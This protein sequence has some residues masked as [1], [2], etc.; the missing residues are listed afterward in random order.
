MQTVLTDSLEKVLGETVPRP[1]ERHDGVQ[2][3]GFL[4]EVLSVQLALRTDEPEMRVALSGG[5]ADRA[6]LQVVR[7]VP[8][9]SPVRTAPRSSPSRQCS[10]ASTRTACRR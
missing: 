3:A 5:L 10:C 8:A 1:A 6:R 4:D 9:S 2:V 7:R